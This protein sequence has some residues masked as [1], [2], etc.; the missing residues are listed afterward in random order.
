MRIFAVGALAP[1]VASAQSVQL[2]FSDAANAVVVADQGTN[3]WNTPAY[4][5]RSGFR[6][7]WYREP[8]VS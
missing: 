4:V 3:S 5:A 2:D 8:V 1:A 7:Q 6:L